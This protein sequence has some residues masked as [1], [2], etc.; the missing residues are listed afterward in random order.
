DAAQQGALASAIRAGQHD[1]PTLAGEADV[2]EHVFVRMH[3]DKPFREAS[4][5]QACMMVSTRWR[6]ALSYEKEFEPA[7]KLADARCAESA[8]QAA[9]EEQLPKI[10]TR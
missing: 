1:Q 5:S 8:G 6:A 7:S 2:G 9:R 4:N 3:V 10:R